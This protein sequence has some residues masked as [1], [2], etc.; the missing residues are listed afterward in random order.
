MNTTSNSSSKFLFLLIFMAILV[1]GFLFAS[2]PEIS[3]A[4]TS[5]NNADLYYS[6]PEKISSIVLS[7]DMEVYW[8]ENENFGDNLY[9]ADVGDLFNENTHPLEKH[10]V[11]AVMTLVCINKGRGVME[12]KRNDGRKAI[13]CNINI[14]DLLE[15]FTLEEIQRAEP[16]MTLEKLESYNGKFGVGI[17]EKGQQNVTL[18]IKESKNTL[19]QVYKYL[20]NSG[21]VE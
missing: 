18:F 6:E 15:L 13:I 3:T 12:L 7:P 11:K 10:G 9:L 20:S 19:A 1:I 2:N 5:L 21:F 8:G 14:E 4:V 17:F 16:R